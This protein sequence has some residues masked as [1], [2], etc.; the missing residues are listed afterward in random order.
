MTDPT[1]DIKA[2]AENTAAT[3]ARV[4]PT[5]KILYPSEPKLGD[6]IQIAVPK[7]FELKEVDTQKKLAN[8]R[9]A[10]ARVKFNWCG[11]IACMKAPRI[12]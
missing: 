2:P 6:V 1:T 9:L 10:R 3:L 12:D 5:P 8:P 4:L 11:P 7:G